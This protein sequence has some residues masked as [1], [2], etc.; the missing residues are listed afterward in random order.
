VSSYHPHLELSLE[1]IAQAVAARDAHI[2][3]II[4]AIDLIDDLVTCKYRS[5]SVLVDQ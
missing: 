1:V 3:D 2:I 4:G 5:L